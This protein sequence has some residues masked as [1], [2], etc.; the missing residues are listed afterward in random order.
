MSFR[1]RVSRAL[2][3]SRFPAMALSSR[4]LP[5]LLRGPGEPSS[6]ALRGTTK[7][8]RLPIAYP[9]SLIG[10]LPRP[11]GYLRVRVRRSAPGS[12][13]GSF[14]A[15]ALVG[16]AAPIAV[17]DYVDANGISQVSR[18]SF[19]CLCSAPRPRSNRRVL[20]VPG[21]IDAA[22]ATHT[23]KASAIAISGLTHAASAPADLRFAFYVATHAQGSIPAGWLAFAGRASNPLDRNERFQLVLTII[24]LSCS[25]DAN[26]LSEAKP[27]IA[28][29]EW[30]D[31]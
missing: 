11:T 9:W 29:S 3:P 18:R 20:A 5:S 16:P 31:S 23:T 24:P 22:P 26:G 28:V 15:R 27:I 14:R 2:V 1:V 6:P 13:E 10:S 4:R 25:P 8:L 12:S 19:P 7:A 21:H 30:L 17:L